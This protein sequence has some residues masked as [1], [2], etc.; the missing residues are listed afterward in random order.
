MWMHLNPVHIDTICELKEIAA[1]HGCK[2]AIHIED[3]HTLEE[4]LEE[5]LD[6]MVEREYIDKNLL[7][8]LLE[9]YYFSDAVYQ[10][11]VVCFELLEPIYENGELDHYY[12]H[13]MIYN[14][15]HMWMDYSKCTDV[16]P[17]KEILEWTE[18]NFDD[19]EGGRYYIETAITDVHGFK[20]VQ[21]KVNV[22]REGMA[23]KNFGDL[24]CD[25]L[26]EPR[27]VKNY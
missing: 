6:F 18:E 3:Y 27:I 20:G 10:H 19:D 11:D 24:V 12:Y 5:V 1:R 7:D 2:I 22:Y 14:D 21:T 15:Y 16:H 23:L 8:E 17:S 9:D 25:Y 13:Q 26:G 4:A